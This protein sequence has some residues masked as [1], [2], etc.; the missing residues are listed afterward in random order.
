[1]D[2]HVGSL[3]SSGGTSRAGLGGG[4]KKHCLLCGLHARSGAKSRMG[5]YKPDEGGKDV[6]EGGPANK[7]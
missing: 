4:V 5:P 7:Y 1:M 3:R 2:G 6:Q